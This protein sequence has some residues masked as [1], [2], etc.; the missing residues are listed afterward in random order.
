VNDV[1]TAVDGQQL[2]GESDFALIVSRH[3]PGDTITLTVLRDGQ[4]L[5]VQLTLG[6]APS[7]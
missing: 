4:Q 7:P 5:S 1:I 2:V 6:E 3:K